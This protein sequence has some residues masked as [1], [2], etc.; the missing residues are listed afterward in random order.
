MAEF[1][2]RLRLEMAVYQLIHQPERPIADIAQGLGFSSAQNFA[3]ACRHG[4]GQT[5]SQLRHPSH[6]LTLAAAGP[7]GPLAAPALSSYNFV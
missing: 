4:T 6:R 3:R 5:P 2:R 1:R 7:M